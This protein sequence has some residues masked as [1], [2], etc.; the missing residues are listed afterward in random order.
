MEGKKKLTIGYFETQGIFEPSAATRRALN[1]AREALTKRGHKLVEM[2]MTPEL[3][4]WTSAP[5]YYAIMGAVGNMSDMSRAL[6]GEPFHSSYSDLYRLTNIPSI[7][8][9]VI[10][11]VLGALGEQRK[12]LIMS[13]V[14]DGGSSCR[15]LWDVLIDMQ[16]YREA[17]L[18]ATSD[19]DVILCPGFPIPAV[20]H[21]QSAKI[22]ITAVYT[23]FANVLQWPIG[24]VPVTKVREEEQSYPL[25]SLPVSQQDSWAKESE[26]AFKDSSGMPIGVQILARPFCDELCLHAMKELEVGLGGQ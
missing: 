13:T 15:Q 4:G 2:K 14:R 5:I 22:T 25:A 20:I 11:L 8:L 6:E 21:D 23:F 12:K 26:K 19:F 9:P 1:E 7:L 16:A 3:S 24:A 17:W 18:E 10:K